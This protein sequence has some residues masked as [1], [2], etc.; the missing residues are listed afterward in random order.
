[1]FLTRSLPSREGFL[2]LHYNIYFGIDLFGQW[3]YAYLIAAIGTAVLV[4]NT[5]IV[6]SIY[7][8]QPTLAV[9]IG[10]TTPVLE[11]LLAVAANAYANHLL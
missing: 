7:Q 1:V 4:L 11:T 6:F 2:P 9:L 5:I 8:R 10:V 3:Y